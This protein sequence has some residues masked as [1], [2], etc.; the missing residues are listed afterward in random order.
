L[1]VNLNKRGMTG[2]RRSTFKS[3]KIGKFSQVAAGRQTI[4]KSTGAV[5]GR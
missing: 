3:D 4:L 2:S 1:A 5:A